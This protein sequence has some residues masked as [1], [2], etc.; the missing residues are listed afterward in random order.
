VGIKKRVTWRD[1]EGMSIDGGSP[2]SLKTFFLGFP[3]EGGR[4]FP[5]GA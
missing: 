4:N 2:I 5:Y 1:R 3:H